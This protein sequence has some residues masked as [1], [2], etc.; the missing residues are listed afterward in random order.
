MLS[1]FRT[2]NIIWDGVNKRINQQ[3]DLIHGGGGRVLA[4][5]VLNNG[6]VVNT[7]GITLSL[8]WEVANGLY[9][10]VDEFKGADET[11]GKYQLT[12]P[13]NMVKKVGTVRASL[14]L[15][16]KGE[17]PISSMAFDIHVKEAI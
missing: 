7:K 14:E 3:I 9:Q 16:A 1:Q 11:L 8:R 10:G 6:Q 5:Q 15:S 12:P 17:V 4:V 13:E 2:I